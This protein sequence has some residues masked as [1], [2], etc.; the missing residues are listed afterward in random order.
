MPWGGC[1]APAL[2]LAEHRRL[3]L[4]HAGLKIVCPRRR[5]TRAP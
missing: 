5:T 2:S 1:A 3:V 4:P